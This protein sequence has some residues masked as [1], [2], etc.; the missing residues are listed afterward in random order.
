VKGSDVN[1]IAAQKRAEREAREQA[2]AARERQAFIGERVEAYKQA[3]VE[4]AIDGLNSFDFNHD[5]DVSEVG[6]DGAVAIR[7]ALTDDGFTVTALAPG[8]FRITWPQ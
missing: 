8:M 5:F 6:G 7:Q 4:A 2:Q 1:T 3:C